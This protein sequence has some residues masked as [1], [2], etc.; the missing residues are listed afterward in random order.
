VIIGDR[1]CGKTSLLSVFTSGYLSEVNIIVNSNY[2]NSEVINF[3][4]ALRKIS[5]TSIR[6]EAWTTCVYR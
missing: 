2:L 5:F 4:Q 1:S 6:V 3:S